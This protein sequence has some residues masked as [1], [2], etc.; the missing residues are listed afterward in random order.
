MDA[1]AVLGCPPHLSDPS[2][3]LHVWF[4]RPNGILDSLT[5]P[6][7]SNALVAWLTGPATEQMWQRFGRNGPPLIFIHHWAR[8]RSYDLAAR[9]R[10]V[11]WGLSMGVKPST[12]S[13]L[14]WGRNRR[15]WFAWRAARGLSRLRWQASRWAW[16]T[17]SMK[18]FHGWV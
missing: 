11:T 10:L 8:A 1:H 6:H 13:T 18:R 16:R 7:M 12:A 17:A 2:G 14:C 9:A 3:L 5:G 4:T 15:R